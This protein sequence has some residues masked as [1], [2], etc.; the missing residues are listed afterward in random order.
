MTKSKKHFLIALV[1]FLLLMIA[2]GV[3][4]S[5]RTVAPWEKGNIQTKSE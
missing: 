3:D 1:I 5:R 4:I 2:I